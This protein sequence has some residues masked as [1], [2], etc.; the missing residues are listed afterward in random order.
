ML[1]VN[2]NQLIETDNWTKGWV[3]FLPPKNGRWGH[4]MYLW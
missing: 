1:S 4:P 2:Q 3:V